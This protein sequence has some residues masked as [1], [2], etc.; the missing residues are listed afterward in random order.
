MNTIIETERL[1]L[2]TW[3]PS[4]ANSLGYQSRSKS[5]LN[6]WWPNERG[7]SASIYANQN[8]QQAQKGFTLWVV[9]L[10]TTHELIGFIGLNYIDWAAAF[11]PAVEVGWRLG[12]QYW[13]KRLC[14]RRC[15]S[16]TRL[17]I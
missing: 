3:E 1:Y 2:R 12:S 16:C 6:F 17:R 15:Q 14:D 9:E 13:G 8:Q 10:K 7:S 11:T 4:D 5:P